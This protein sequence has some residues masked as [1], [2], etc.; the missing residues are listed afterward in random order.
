MTEALLIVFAIVSMLASVLIARV[1]MGRTW[2]LSPLFLFVVTSILFINIGFIK[3]FMDYSDQHW[4]AYALLSCSVGLLL[5]SS[6][7]FLAALILNVPMLWPRVTSTLIRIDFSFGIAMRTA[8]VVFTIVLLYFYLLGYIPILE[9]VKIL[10]TQGF[11]AG[12]VN[13]LRIGRDVYVNPE[14][15]YIPLQGFMQAIR[16]FGLPI[17]AVWFLHLYRQKV[18]TRLSLAMLLSSA[19]LMVLTG[20]RWPLMYM[21]L[22]LIIYWSWTESNL[23]KYR[24]VI[25]R[26]GVTAFVTG[27]ILSMLLGRTTQSGL[28]ITEMALLGLNDLFDRIF[29][30][31]VKVPFISYRIFPQEENWLYG[32]SWIQNLLAFLPGPLPSYP[33]TFYQMVTGDQKGFTAPPD[34]YTE[35][36]INFGWLGLVVISF[37][38]G[39]LLVIF[40]RILIG[41]RTSLL[42]TSVLAMM[43]TLIAF[44]GFS[45]VIF[46]VGGVIVSIFIS[47]VVVLQRKFLLKRQVPS[48]ILITR[49]ETT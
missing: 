17:V 5:V 40:Q 2:A 46:L 36:Y 45:G 6:G 39:F 30:G 9:G 38:W 26:L 10:L 25:Q 22:T 21:F 12:L 47:M 18:R 42:R 13:N 33:V 8:C 31:N 27:G 41:I 11:I 23:R 32:W 20:Q 48:N 29:L 44:S 35:A 19:V 49:G 14:A 43:S 16:Y 1:S 28:N 4:A 7:G 15:A 37:C 3:S 34:F 24:R